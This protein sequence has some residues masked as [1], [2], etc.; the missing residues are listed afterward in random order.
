MKTRSVLAIVAVGVGVSV[1]GAGC[2]V[3]AVSGDPAAEPVNESVARRIKIGK[4]DLSGSCAAGDNNWCGQKSTGNCHCDKACLEYGDCCADYAAI[5]GQG[6]PGS[7]KEL[8]GICLSSPLDVTFAANCEKDFG[9]KPLTGAC[10]AFNQSCCSKP[11]CEPVSCE[12]YCKYGFAT[13]DQGCEIC[14]CNEPSCQD[15]C[16]GT[17]TDNAC[18]CDAACQKYGDCCDDYQSVCVDEREPATGW[19]VRN[20]GDTCSTDA[21]CTAGG[22][23]GELCYNPA[24]GSGISTCDCSTPTNVS[25]CGCLAGKCSWYK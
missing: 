3:E 17:A 14:A 25:G 12:L 13:D 22:C 10:P 18:Y 24:V 15:K 4:A 7:C 8:G 19:C 9:L 23:G 6:E 16:G 11:A 1:S 2:T 5:C 20:S 21:D